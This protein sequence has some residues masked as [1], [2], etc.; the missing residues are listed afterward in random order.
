[1]SDPK[2]HE[3]AGH[4]A[5]LPGVN[6]LTKL[7]VDTPWSSAEIYLHGAHVTDFRLHGQPPL[8]FLS[9]ASDYADGK[10]IRGGIPLIFPWFGPR[11]GHPAHGFARTREWHLLHASR[12]PE[13]VVSLFLSLPEA[14]GLH[15]TYE[16]TV[17]ETLGLV[18]RIANP[19]SSPVTFEDCLH[20]Y[21]HI[22][23]IEFISLTGLEGTGYLDK[24]AG[25]AASGGADPLVIDREVDRIY[26][27]TAATVDIVD[28]ALGRRIRV[29]KSGSRSTVVWNPW[30]EKS[31]RMPDFGD[32][33]F[34]HMVCVE[35]GNV[36][37]AA[38]TLPPGGEHALG[39]DLS[40]IP[41]DQP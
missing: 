5:V 31:H 3:I 6:G 38:I 14:D 22:G 8:L 37:A 1:M 18:L 11:D 21:F 36:A 26:Q 17:G 33:E 23:G 41:A 29:A 12:T 27:D 32:D 34:N 19:T 24:V 35:S 13:G 20:T 2:Q 39:V 9:A 16:V 40:V 7:V 15:V 10:P 4:L 30:I 25:A 28:P